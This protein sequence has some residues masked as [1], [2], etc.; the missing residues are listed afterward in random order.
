M[1]VLYE[2]CCG[3]DVHKKTVV[4]CVV[5]T[6]PEEPMQKHVRTFATTTTSLLALADWL[7]AL[8][9]SHIALESIGIYWRPCSICWKRVVPLFWSMR[10]I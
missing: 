3:L 6:S 7:T 4:A 8:Q 10:S 2:R 1:Q 5:I 9:V